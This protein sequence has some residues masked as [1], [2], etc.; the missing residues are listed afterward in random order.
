MNHQDSHCCCGTAGE[1][2]TCNRMCRPAA[3]STDVIETRIHSIAALRYPGCS[4]T[5][6]GTIS[7]AA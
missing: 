4:I 2:V 5:S 3:T 1:Q 6:G 7:L